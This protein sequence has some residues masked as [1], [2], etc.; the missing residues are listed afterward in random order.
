MIV[1]EFYNYRY[2]KSGDWVHRWCQDTATNT[3]SVTETLRKRVYTHSRITRTNEKKRKDERK[4]REGREGKG[5]RKGY[6]IV[7]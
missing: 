5:K 7:C 2:L 3:Y 1:V 6:P 4:G